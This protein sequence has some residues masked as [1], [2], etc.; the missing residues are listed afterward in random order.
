[1]TDDSVVDE[2]INSLENRF[3]SPKFLAIWQRWQDARNAWNKVSTHVPFKEMGESYNPTVDKI[4][5]PNQRASAQEFLDARQ[6][7]KEELQ[8]RSGIPM[9]Y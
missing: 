4:R 5:D 6:A 7:Y 2:N 3:R 8:R 1:M 9:I